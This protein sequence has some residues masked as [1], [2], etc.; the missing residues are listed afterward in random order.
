MPAVV[1]NYCSGGHTLTMPCQDPLARV[2]RAWF[3]NRRGWP[4]QHV[5]SSYLL[6]P[7]NQLTSQTA[8]SSRPG[9]STSVQY[10]STPQRHVWESVK[11]TRR[12]DATYLYSVA[13]P[14]DP[15]ALQT[16]EL[17]TCKFSNWLQQMRVRVCKV[18]TPTLQKW[19]HMKFIA[20]STL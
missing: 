20:Q 2:K 9:I 19:G 11:T 7:L 16:H 6:A 17:F 15:Q 8:F 5:P 10:G 18:R 1:G 14:T 3:G 13:K 12:S 4:R